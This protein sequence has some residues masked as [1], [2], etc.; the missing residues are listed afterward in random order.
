MPKLHPNTAERSK[1]EVKEV[2]FKPAK[3]GIVSETRRE[4][5]RG[6]Q[7]GGPSHDY[8]HE[9]AVHPDMKSAHAHMAAMMGHCFKGE[10]EGE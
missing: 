6:G 2:S 4:F 10:K 7:G 8:E 9:T 1:G 3:G 5:K